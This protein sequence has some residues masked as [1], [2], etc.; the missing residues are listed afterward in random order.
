MSEVERDGMVTLRMPRRVW[1]ELLSGYD[2][3]VN[4]FCCNKKE[5]QECEQIQNIAKASLVVTSTPTSKSTH[6]T[7]IT[8]DGLTVE[9]PEEEA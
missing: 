2:M 4:E 5:F 6:G 9:P 1:D 8:P 3:Y 7:A